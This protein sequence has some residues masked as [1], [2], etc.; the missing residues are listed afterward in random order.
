MTSHDPADSENRG[1]KILSSIA[2][3]LNTALSIDEALKIT[4]AKL[5]KW[6][7]LETGWVWLL[8]SGSEEPYLAAAQNLPPALADNPAEME[9]TCYC[10]DTFK[11]RNLE[12]AAN[13]NMVTCSR[14][15]W[16]RQGTAGLRYH[17]SI[18]LYANERKMGVLNLASQ[19][20]RELTAGELELLYTIGDMLGIA[21][22]R[23]QLFYRSTQLGAVEERNRLAREIHDTLAQDLAGLTLQLESADVL[24]EGK[25][26]PQKVRQIIQ[27]ALQMSRQ[28]LEEVQ[29]SVLDLRAAPLVGRSLPEA[30]ADLVHEGEAQADLKIHL[31]TTG[32]QR[33]LSSRLEI[34]LYRI[35]QEGVR[36]IIQ[37][38][39]AVQATVELIV[40]PE[41]IQL[42][43][44][45]D[46]RGFDTN[47]H[48]NDCF[49]LIGINERV[50]LLGGTLRLE[51][52]PG[53]GTR[54]EVRIP[55]AD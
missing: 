53:E 54:L 51:S 12:G 25:R 40:T 24:L 14:L 28:S 44:I 1:L 5:S 55:I 2:Q 38:A 42:L 50:N 33:P 4:L 17:A 22:E 26:N 37:H 8:E 47:H 29:R 52:A 13:V 20:W 18:P 11:A 7:E 30:L 31:M 9:G 43:I 23:A 48:P 19:D 49:G 45:D 10:L 35:V 36:N 41:R 21:L 34:A 39:G 27:Q 3:A 46:G 32:L 6:F 16:L 15:K